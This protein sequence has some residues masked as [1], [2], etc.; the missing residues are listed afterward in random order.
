MKKTTLFMACCI[1]LM[2][3]A[4]CKKDVQPTI[5]IAIGSNYA[6]Q[7]TEV[8]AG[9]P[10][11]VAFSVTGENLTKIEMNAMQNGT[12]LYTD[13]QNIDNAASFLYVHNF[14]L[15]AIGTVN[16][17]GIVTDAKGHTATINFDIFCYEKPNAKF[18]GRY[19]GD[20]IINGTFNIDVTNLDP[21][22]D[23]M[24]DHPY[25]TIVTM[26]A[27]D[28]MDEV[29]AVISINEQED[30]VK[31]TVD[32]H[33]VVFEAINDTYTMYYDANGMTIPIDINMT[34]TITGTLNDGKLQLDGDCKG[35]GEFN[36]L[37]I[38]GNIE[39]EGVISGSLDKT[40]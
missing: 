25:P 3:L 4:S 11:T 7:S 36:M 33:K 37:F 20:A 38:N 35:N 2:L 39:M 10:I 6:S 27:G 17:N 13:A 18:V 28:N 40:E 29:I 5:G 21:I 8:F 30:T 9:D 31:G 14:T 23:T 34:Y 32:G 12:V 16:I 15:E 22:H 26:E 1:G 19:Q 24:A